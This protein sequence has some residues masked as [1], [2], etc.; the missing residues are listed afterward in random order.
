M[1]NFKIIFLRFWRCEYKALDLGIRDFT[2][3]KS[4]RL[5]KETCSI[6]K[7]HGITNY[8]RTTTHHNIALSQKERSGYRATVILY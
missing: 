8:S 2:F 5:P 3:Q 7:F 4:C 1:R 6:F